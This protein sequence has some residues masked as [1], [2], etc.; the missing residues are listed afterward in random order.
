MLT[1]RLPHAARVPQPAQ[2]TDTQREGG[3]LRITQPL[4]GRLDLNLSS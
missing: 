2:F 4:R 3:V 1:A